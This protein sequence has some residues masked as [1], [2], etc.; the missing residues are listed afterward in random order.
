MAWEQT[1]L[2]HSL[3]QLHKKELADPGPESSE[4]QHPDAVNA[5]LTLVLSSLVF[6]VAGSICLACLSGATLLAKPLQ[7]DAAEDE[8]F[9]DSPSSCEP[10]YPK[11][12]V[13]KQFLGR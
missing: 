3:L 13:L 8:A 4:L 5:Y 9:E 7:E 10:E 2:T 11:V 12:S 6:M 1:I